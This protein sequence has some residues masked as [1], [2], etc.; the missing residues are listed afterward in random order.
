MFHLIWAAQS[1]LTD[2]CQKY[3]YETFF[4]N[5]FGFKHI[6]KSLNVTHSE[7]HKLPP[8]ERQKVFVTDTDQTDAST[9]RWI[10]KY[11]E[12]LN[13]VDWW[14]ATNVVDHDLKIIPV[15][16]GIDYHTRYRRH[17]VSPRDQEAKLLELRQQM[18][19]FWERKV[20][21]FADFHT[22]STHSHPPRIEARR[23]IPTKLV[24]YSEGYMDRN[25]LWQIYTQYA[26]VASPA[27][28][29]LDCHRHWEILA[30]GGIPV[31]KS[32]GIDPIFDDLPVL[33]VD[34]WSDLTQKL[35][36]E[37]V[38]RFQN[39]TF[40]YERLTLDHYRNLLIQK[41]I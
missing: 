20:R 1:Q 15:P 27:G 36:D 30:L 4:H 12:I 13:Q 2:E 23:M 9:S 39:M 22:G 21:I 11:G 33:I 26:F 38:V 7:L 10:P 5:R 6:A 31:M 18:K 28:N 41:L 37:T 40:N 8:I 19:P 17:K 24:T 14:F 16:L 32:S 3:P 29:G 35:L 25:Q 34:S